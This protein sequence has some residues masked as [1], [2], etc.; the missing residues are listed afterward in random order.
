MLFRSP[1]YEKVSDEFPNVDCYRVEMEQHPQLAEQFSVEAFPAFIFIATDGKMKKWVG[2]LPANE[3]A[4]FVKEA[5]P[6]V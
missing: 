4:G 5:F 1:R 2:E 6:G 3:L